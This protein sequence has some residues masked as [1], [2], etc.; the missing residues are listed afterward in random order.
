MYVFARELSLVPGNAHACMCIHL[1][2]LFIRGREGGGGVLNRVLCV[3]VC[4]LTF[5]KCLP[6]TRLQ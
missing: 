1:F 3:C 6:Y 5:V 2:T 4:V